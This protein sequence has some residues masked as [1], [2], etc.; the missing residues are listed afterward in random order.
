MAAANFMFVINFELWDIKVCVH[1]YRASLN[2]TISGFI[3]I[4]TVGYERSLQFVRYNNI[5]YE[6]GNCLNFLKMN[7]GELSVKKRKYSDEFLKYGFTC[8]C[9]SIVVEGIEIPQ[10]VICNDVLLAESMKPNKLKRHFYTKHQNF[11]DKDVQYFKNKADGV[12]KGRLDASTVSRQL[13][14]GH[15]VYD[16]SSTDISSTD[17]SSTMTFLTT[18]E[19]GVMKHILN[20]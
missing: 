2:K 9:T 8:T 20:Q 17:I 13:V 14:Y 4:N 1:F 10:C 15:F 19:A 18:I 5:V 12:K 11:S 6:T 16:T 3:K 7:E